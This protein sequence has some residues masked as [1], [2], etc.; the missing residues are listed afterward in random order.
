MFITVASAFVTRETLA[1]TGSFVV[2]CSPPL[3]LPLGIS[4]F[5]TTRGIYLVSLFIDTM[6]ALL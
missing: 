4:V 3:Y 2:L 5:D 1:V 6:R